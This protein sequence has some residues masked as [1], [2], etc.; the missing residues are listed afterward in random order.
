MEWTPEMLRQVMEQRFRGVVRVY[1]GFNALA[2]QEWH[3]RLDDLIIES[4][5]NSP[6]RMLRVA[7][8]LIDAHA[9]QP[10]EKPN[11]RLQDWNAMRRD[12]QYGIL[13]P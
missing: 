2:N 1:D 5:R 7:S 6:Q 12:W 9:F 4:A 8:G 13:D 10:S 3:D 11:I